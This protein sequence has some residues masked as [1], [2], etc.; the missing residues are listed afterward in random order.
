M[1]IIITIGI[2]KLE[3]TDTTNSAIKYHFDDIKKLITSMVEDYK[4]LDL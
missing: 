2:L 1:K 3:M 4:K